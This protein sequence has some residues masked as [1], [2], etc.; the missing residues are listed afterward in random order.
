MKKTVAKLIVKT[1]ICAL[2]RQA[3]MINTSLLNFIKFNKKRMVRIAPPSLQT[4]LLFII[5]II[6][7]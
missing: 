6:I 1:E 7:S 3:D 5:I 4:S 2:D